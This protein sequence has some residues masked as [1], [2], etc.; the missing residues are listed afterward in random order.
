MGIEKTGMGIE[1]TG[2]GIEKTG[3]GIQKIWKG[4]EKKDKE[5]GIQKIVKVNI[6]WNSY[7]F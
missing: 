1:K 7:T 3:M 5:M 4:I 6:D 2:M